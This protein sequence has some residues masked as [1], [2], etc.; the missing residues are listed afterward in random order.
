MPPMVD[1]FEVGPHTVE[2]HE[3]IEI[4]GAGFPAGRRAEVSFRGTMSTPGERPA[5]VDIAADGK[6]TSDET[7][8]V[9]FDEVLE[10]R[11]A[12]RGADLRHST[13]HGSVEVRFTTLGGALVHG[14]RDGVDLD[15]RPKAIADADAEE[16]GREALGKLGISLAEGDTLLLGELAPGG[17]AAQ[18]GLLPGDRLVELA[19][20]RLHS[21]ADVSDANVPRPL[22]IRYLRAGE[23][24]ERVVSIEAPPFPRALPSWLTFVVLGFAVLSLTVAL[25][26]SRRMTQ[27]RRWEIALGVLLRDRSRAGRGVPTLR[28]A[29]G[30]WG[31]SFVLTLALA[32]VPLVPACAELDVP[33]LFVAWLAA[34]IVL[35]RP[36]E[37]RMKSVR[38][39]L[40]WLSE[41]FTSITPLAAVVVIGV[42]QT[43]AL[44]LIDLS[45]AQSAWRWLAWQA[46]WMTMA[47]A[48]A[49]GSFG[50]R[51]TRTTERLVHTLGLALFVI[52]ALGG[53]EPAHAG[54]FG[55]AWA[56]PC[57]FVCKM[58][59]LVALSRGL[60]VWAERAGSRARHEAE[61]G[62]A[63]SLSVLVVAGH[64]ALG[65]PGWLTEWLAPSLAVLV[66]LAAV[67][68]LTR[69]LAVPV[70]HADELDPA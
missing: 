34:R 58:V 9:L 37:G 64:F 8:A 33:T 23:A 13:F 45:A 31:P 3:R 20:V 7:I 46:P 55:F 5:H 62:V 26:A 15:V 18:H 38:G 29:A 47:A 48:L 32:I 12:G 10:Q 4:R 19:G 27:L 61:S 17:V 43:A 60:T 28:A 68:M 44:R 67:V 40:S 22:S 24:D 2:R 65:A 66:G 56:V 49:L 36:R 1:V 14:T 70:D 42:H 25:F 63:A 30:S 57:A 35:V 53:W 69:A 39:S 52:T 54:P 41:A 16:R 51:A 11:F 59:L 21:A 6:V 50:R